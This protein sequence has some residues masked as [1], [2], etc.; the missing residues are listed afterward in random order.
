MGGIGDESQCIV[1]PFA[2]AGFLPNCSGRT[3]SP[4]R[5]V[6][7]PQPCLQPLLRWL[8]CFRSSALLFALPV[9]LISHLCLFMHLSQ[10][11]LLHL[12][13]LAFILLWHLAF[14]ILLCVYFCV[15][16]PFLNFL[17]WSHQ[18]LLWFHF[19][20]WW[21]PFVHHRAHRY[22]LWLAQS[23]PWLP[24]TWV[25]LAAPPPAAK[26]LPAVPRTG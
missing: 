13:C 14:C 3:C 4:F 17:S 18:G 25:A 7:P 8:L 1:V 2:A 9:C 10:Y 5:V 12:L 21:V 24:P 6:P 16:L 20:A 15:Y 23:S 19:G 26:A 22:Q 11:Q